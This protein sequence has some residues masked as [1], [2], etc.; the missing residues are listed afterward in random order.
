M[1][2]KAPHD[3]GAPRSGTP[4]RCVVRHQLVQSI[5]ATMIAAPVTL[6]AVVLSLR[7][8]TRPLQALYA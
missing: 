2:L 7:F 3:N 8:L 1:S 6:T 5:E 4:R